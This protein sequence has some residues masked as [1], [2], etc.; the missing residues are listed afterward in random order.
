MSEKVDKIVST[1]NIE[2]SESGM[3]NIKALSNGE[4]MQAAMLER[5]LLDTYNMLRDQR[6][7]QETIRILTSKEDQ[8]NVD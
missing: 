1:V 7:V 3:F 5:I 6:V 2:I 8:E 4:P